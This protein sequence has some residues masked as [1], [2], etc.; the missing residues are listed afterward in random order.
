MS[1]KA[2]TAIP[3][4]DGLDKD[5]HQERRLLAGQLR[6]TQESRDLRARMDAQLAAAG[7]DVVT[8]TIHLGTFEVRRAVSQNGSRYATVT[9]IADRSD[10]L[11]R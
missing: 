1:I 8:V 10:E 9:K 3:G 11:I 5:V 6:I 7:V 4:L 2:H